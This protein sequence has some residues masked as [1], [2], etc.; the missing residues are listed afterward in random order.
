MTANLSH[1]STRIRFGLMDLPS[2]DA[3]LNP[4]FEQAVSNARD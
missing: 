4:F 3:D 2:S 1:P